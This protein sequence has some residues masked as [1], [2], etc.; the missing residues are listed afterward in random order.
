MYLPKYMC[1]RAC[2]CLS[3]IPT[4]LTRRYP[5]TPKGT[6]LLYT[7]AHQP[8][9]PLSFSCGGACITQPGIARNCSYPREL[10]HRDSL[11]PRSPVHIKTAACCFSV[12]E[13]GIAVCLACMPRSAQVPSSLGACGWVGTRT[14]ERARAP[15][16]ESLFPGSW[17]HTKKKA[18]IQSPDLRA[19]EIIK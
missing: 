18:R 3:V 11:S 8:P 15:F 7:E 1:T 17:V 5:N 6:R 19:G 2:V 4:N 14:C 9:L 12:G 13:K 10:C 16:S